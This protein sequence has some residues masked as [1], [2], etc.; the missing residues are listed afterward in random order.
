MMVFM[1]TFEVLF[2]AFKDKDISDIPE[3]TDGQLADLMPSP[4]RNPDSS[5]LMNTLEVMFIAFIKTTQLLWI[6]RYGRCRR[7][8]LLGEKCS[9]RCV[10]S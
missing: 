6:C 8:M 4:L 3:M 5:S 9:H 1:K 7:I 10:I 2:I